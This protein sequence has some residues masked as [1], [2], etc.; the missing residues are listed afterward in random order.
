MMRASGRL[1]KK[2]LLYLESKSKYYQAGKWET[3]LIIK[4]YYSE[5]QKCVVYVL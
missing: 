3:D 1:L 4:Y 5:K 2:K